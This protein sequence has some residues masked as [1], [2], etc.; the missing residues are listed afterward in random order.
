MSDHPIGYE[1]PTLR[2]QGAVAGTC[3]ITVQQLVGERREQRYVDARHLSIALCS[4]L[5]PVLS[6]SAIA[7]A[8]RRDH[9][10][11]LAALEHWPTRRF[12]RPHLAALERD[13]RARL[14]A[15]GDA[16]EA[17]PTPGAAPAPGLACPCCGADLEVALSARAQ[18]PRSEAGQP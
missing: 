17:A 8:H 5:L 10:T 1:P 18:S 16:P 7:R 14:S 4:D 15:G 2:I 3:G 6:I 11:V 12:Q 9:T 13:L